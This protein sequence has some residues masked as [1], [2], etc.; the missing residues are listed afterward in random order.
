MTEGLR[1]DPLGRRFLRG[2]GAD[3]GVEIEPGHAP[4]A[5]RQVLEQPLGDEAQLNVSLVGGELAADVL[6]VKLGLALHILLAAAAVDGIHVLHPEVIRVGPDGVNG[7]LEADLNLEAPAV[8]ANNLQRVQ[9]QIG[10]K[11]DQVPARRMALPTQTA[12]AGPRGA[13]ANR[14]L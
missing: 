13:R 14:K 2:G 6:P 10:A 3:I 9:G 1:D 5:Q 11:E 7:L 4:E 12:P 8:K